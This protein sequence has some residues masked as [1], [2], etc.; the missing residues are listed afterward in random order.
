MSVDTW[1]ALGSCQ[2]IHSSARVSG[3]AAFKYTENVCGP[4]WWG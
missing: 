4:P 2:L 3:S 1:M